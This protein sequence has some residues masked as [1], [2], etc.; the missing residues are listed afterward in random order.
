MAQDAINSTLRLYADK[1]NDEGYSHVN[2]LSKGL[3]TQSEM[4]SPVVTH[5]YY[6]QGSQNFPLSFLTEGMGKIKSISSA[7]LSYQTP[8]MGR[9]KTDS[10][11]TTSLY[12]STDKP[13]LG[14]TDFIIPFADKW[15]KENQ[16]L[17]SPVKEVQVHVKEVKK[18]TNTQYNCRV[19]LVTSSKANFC[20]PSLLA[21]GVKWAGG[22]V[23]VGIANSVGTEHRSQTP[24]KMTNQLS[25]V[26]DT[27]KIRGNVENKIMVVEIPTENGNIKY[28][29][30]FEYY[31][32]N[33]EWKEVCEDDLWYS[34]YNKSEEGEI[35]T[36]DEAAGGEVTPS[37]AG[38]LQQISNEDT[39]ANMT[40]EKLTQIIRN[41]FFNAS[42]GANKK[43]EVFTGTGGLEE[44]DK[45]MKEGAKNFTLVDSKFV[46]G[47]K[48][49]MIYGAYFKA[50]RHVDGH[51]VTF[52]HLP[53]MDRGRIAKISDPHPITGLPME[54]YNMYFLDMT[55]YDGE[56]NIQYVS[57]KGREQVDFIVAGAK[58]PNGYSETVYRATSRD[59]SSI[60][61]MKSQGVTIKRPTNCFKAFC[62]LN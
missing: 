57:E 44:V 37:G 48:F 29:S 30:E 47:S 43:I 21:A 55:T 12:A 6:K 51:V 54:S 22:I 8:I 32:K 13:G 56:D 61:T 5:L 3:L 52:R 17:Y 20:P 28:W 10:T 36:V 42:E 4:L 58:V 2:H 19:T 45:A 26:R 16:I 46:E 15:F 40:T 34:I 59:G 7:D 27:F 33:L 14:G 53:L 24:G 49:D 39:Y 41:A 62:T 1:Y 35:L 18:V 9:P 11:I 60:E 31:L 25:V 50:F 38:V 23:K